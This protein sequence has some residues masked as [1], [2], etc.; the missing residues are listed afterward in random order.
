MVSPGQACEY[1]R[2]FRRDLVF[3][4]REVVQHDRW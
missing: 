1:L 3:R 2:E 4:P